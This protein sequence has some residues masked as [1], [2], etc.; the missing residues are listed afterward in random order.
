MGA[1]KP[2]WSSKSP[3]PEGEAMFHKAGSVHPKMELAVL[4]ASVLMSATIF[5]AAQKKTDPASVFAPDKGKL[6]IMLDGK[7]VGHE[8]F[9]I[10][11]SGAGWRAKG[12]TE[13]KAPEGAATRVN[14]TLT[15]QPN[16]APVAYEWTSQAEKT[17]G[18]HVLFANGVARITLEMQGARP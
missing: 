4:A 1:G 5:A 11:P 12:T 17:N 15:L 14:G 8:E 2:T 10:S 9:E 16:G 6:S 18:A 3:S 7:T 13:L